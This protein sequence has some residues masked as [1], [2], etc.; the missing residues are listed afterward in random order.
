[1]N[2]NARIELKLFSIYSFCFK[3]PREGTNLVSFFTVPSFRSAIENAF[4]P[5]IV[6][7]SSILSN[8][9]LRSFSVAFPEIICSWITN[10]LTYLS[11]EAF[12]FPF[13]SFFFP[14]NCDNDNDRGSFAEKSDEASC[15]SAL[16]LFA[17]RPLSV[18]VS[19]PSIS[20]VRSFKL[21]LLLVREE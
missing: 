21:E 4:W 1:M 11:M 12:F 2:R 9:I 15:A 13:V 17:I 14:A 18:R 6:L 16:N 8:V 10:S 7:S 5:S 20:L 19:R 3:I